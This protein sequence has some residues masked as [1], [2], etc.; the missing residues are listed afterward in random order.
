[1]SAPQRI[2]ITAGGAGIGLAIV[3]AFL[4]EGA[5]VH[6]CDVDAEALDPVERESSRLAVVGLTGTQPQ[7]GPRPRGP[8]KSTD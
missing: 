4:R 3:E 2:M 8:T 1:M 5:N 6:V 7:H